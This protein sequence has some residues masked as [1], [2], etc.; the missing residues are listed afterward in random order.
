MDVLALIARHG[1][2]MLGALCFVEAIGIPL[3]AALALLSAGALADQGRLAVA[4]TFAAGLAGL[5]L[6]DTLLYLT[7]RYTGWFF[8]GFLCRMSMN[9]ESCIHKA[10]EAFYKRGRV[11]LLFTKFIPGINTMAAPLAGSLKMSPGQFFLF[12]VAGAL[13]YAG[14]YFGLGYLFSGFLGGIAMRMAAAGEVAKTLLLLGMLAYIVYRVYMA[15]RLRSEFLDIPRVEP[16]E[17]ARVMEECADGLLVFDVRSHGYYGAK[18]IRIKGSNRFEPNRLTE[19]MHELPEAK[20]IY[21]YC[22]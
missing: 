6:G 18:A 11:A 3:P 21:L 13:I 2:L 17:V 12:D 19:A 20:K 16:D 15:R 1:I 10:A 8:L 9:R 4:P 22:T 5:L 14:F 7:G